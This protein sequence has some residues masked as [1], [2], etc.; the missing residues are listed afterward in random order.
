M[1]RRR[2]QE[3]GDLEGAWLNAKAEECYVGRRSVYSDRDILGSAISL[4]N[5]MLVHNGWVSV[6]IGASCARWYNVPDGIMYQP[7]S[8]V[9]AAILEWCRLD[10]ARLRNSHFSYDILFHATR[11]SIAHEDMRGEAVHSKP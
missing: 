2:K 5:G 9:L 3:H 8:P 7:G 4:E 6:D 11:E 10:Y 1:R